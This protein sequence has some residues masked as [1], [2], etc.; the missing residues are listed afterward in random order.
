MTGELIGRGRT[1]GIEALKFTAKQSVAPTKFTHV[2]RGKYM[3]QACLLRVKFVID[4]SAYF[5]VARTIFPSE[6]SCSNF[7]MLPESCVCYSNYL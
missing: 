7:D 3:L 1:D 6:M 5:T 2:Y 4:F